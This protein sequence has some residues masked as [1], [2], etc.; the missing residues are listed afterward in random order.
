M[1]NP[2]LH[3]SQGK[4]VSFM[5][6]LGGVGKSSLATLFAAHLASKNGGEKLVCLVDLDYR[7]GQ[8]S[9]LVE[10]SDPTVADLYRDGRLDR[11]IIL[12]QLAYS[13]K[14]GIHLVLAPQ[15]SRRAESVPAKFYLELV[16]ALTDI[17]DVVVL[18]C[19][20]SKYDAL[21]GVAYCESDKIAFVT[22]PGLPGEDHRWLQEATRKLSEGGRGFHADNIVTIDN[23]RH[24]RPQPPTN[25]A[26]KFPYKE[27]LYTIPGANSLSK[28]LRDYEVQ[29]ALDVLTRKVLG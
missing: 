23:K 4:V 25:G 24:E 18:D 16:K 1:T 26:V 3:N 9:H 12:N 7:D 6:S 5:S 19:S 21:T 11:D 22:T 20:V 28:L 14:L 8:I 2:H 29:D 15:R 13:D 17:F 10:E 27:Q